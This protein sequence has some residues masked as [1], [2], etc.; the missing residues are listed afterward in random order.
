MLA[1]ATRSDRCSFLDRNGVINR[2]SN[3]QSKSFA[4]WVPIPGSLEPI[5]P[6]CCAGFRI[7]IVTN[8]SALA[9]GLISLDAL[10][11]I[12]AALES[13]VIELGGQIAGTYF[14]PHLPEHG[15]GCRKPAPGLVRRAER[16]LGVR[17]AG[18]MF[19]GDKASDVRAARAAGCRPIL[20]ASGQGYDELHEAK[21]LGL[22]IYANLAA[23]AEDALGA[24]DTG[25]SI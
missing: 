4:V 25:V 1:A 3:A 9:R 12:H 6:S 14:C 20:V 8:Q 5:A 24:E 23:F 13:R 11:A 18:A 21:R 10:D 17:A 15:Y 19:V 22:P 7:V 2:D 16:E